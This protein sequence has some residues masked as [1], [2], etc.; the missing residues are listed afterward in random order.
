MTH[1]ARTTAENL[2]HIVNHW[3]QLRA[4]LDTTGPGT[5]WPPARPGA[6]YLR[7]LDD[8]DAAEV[9]AE[10]SLAAAIA[11]SLDHPQ[12]LITTRHHTGQLYYRCAFCDHVGEGLPHPVR[13]D[14]DPAQL[15]E[16]PVPVR[17]HIVDACR[18][19][20]IALVALADSI[21]ARD[22]ADPADWYRA[23]REQRTA[24]AAARWL[25]TR[26]GDDGACCPTHDT[27]RA[28]ITEYAREAA[29]RLDRVLGIGRRSV[30]LPGVPCPW[31]GGD[32]VM[33]SEAGT[34]MSVTCATGLIDCDAPVPFDV[35]RRARVWSSAEQLAALQ[36]A[37]DA[38]EQQRAEAEHRAK[39]AEDR[40]RQRA[41]ARDRAAAA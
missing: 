9:S 38:A 14:R 16:R 2:Q 11:H 10:Q 30:Q 41:A 19:I 1:T 8:Q 13:E 27:D 18:A 35:D 20:E 40:R 26:L 28:R 22:A 32:L 33:H 5:T 12:R 17:L 21:A 7:A 34:V 29:A 31:C 4:A 23:D 3:H 37:L 25:L 39:R 24:P 36:R 6:E 15:G